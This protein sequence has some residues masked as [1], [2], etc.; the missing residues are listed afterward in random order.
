M[1]DIVGVLCVLGGAYFIWSGLARRRQALALAASGVEAPQRHPSLAILGEIGPSIV[2]FM[3]VV[4]ALQISLA[5][6]VS[7]GGGVFSW[8]DLAGFLVL[9]GAYGFWVTMKSRHRV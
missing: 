7:D 5:F 4:A 9:L 1:R 3:L 2:N 8:L 6:V